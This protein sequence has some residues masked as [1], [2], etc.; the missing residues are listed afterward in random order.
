MVKMASPVESGSWPATTD[1]AGAPLS[2]KIA[3][4][5]DDDPA[6]V[7]WVRIYPYEGDLPWYGH[8]PSAGD[9]CFATVSKCVGDKARWW[10]VSLFPKGKDVPFSHCYV[11]SAEKGKAMIERWASYHWRSVVPKRP[12]DFSAIPGARPGKH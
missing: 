5:E 12:K 4:M 10:H 2:S 9:V 7:R 8:L 6:R 11:S 1:E 3:P